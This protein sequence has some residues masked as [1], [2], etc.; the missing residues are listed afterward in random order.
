MRSDHCPRRLLRSEKLPNPVATDSIFRYERRQ[1]VDFLNQQFCASSSDDCP[2]VP[3]S[4]A[5]R[6]FLQTDQT[7]F[8]NQSILWYQRKRGQDSTLDCHLG[9]C[10][11]RDCQKTTGSDH[12]FLHN[13]TNFECDTFR[14]KANFT[15]FF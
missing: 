3:L 6:T 5:N 12:G 15:G 2:T 1:R 10:A 4:M 14:E 8:T 13:F 11:R 7:T 9:L